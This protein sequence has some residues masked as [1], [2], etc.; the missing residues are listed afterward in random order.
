MQLV[1]L[2]CFVH[3]AETLNFSITAQY[4]HVSQPAVSHQLKALEDELNLK[5]LKRTRRNVELTPA[6]LSFYTDTKDIVSRINTAIAKSKSFSET[7]K[8]TLSIGYEGNIFETKY[9]PEIMR[10]FKKK[11][12]HVFI[13]LKTAD[14]SEKYSL[15]AGNKLDIIF[16]D[17]ESIETVT[18]ICYEELFTGKFVCVMPKNHPLARQSTISMDDLL[19]QPLVLRETIKCTPAMKRLQSQLQDNNLHCPI[20]FAD[21]LTLNYTMIKSE[22]GIGVFPDFISPPDDE[23]SIIPLQLPNMDNHISYGVAWRKNNTC[24]ELKAF[25]NITRLTYKKIKFN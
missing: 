22:M 14:Y 21:S 6:G 12:P 3:L 9:F 25:I 2:E 19:T 13:H 24:P 20:Y 7:Y 23:L 4:L 16:S 1:Q 18:N 11:H 5:L 17:K 15:I 8:S 10:A